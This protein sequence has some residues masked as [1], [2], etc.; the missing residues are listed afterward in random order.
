M[1]HAMLLL[2]L[3]L[4]SS[5]T[6]VAQSDDTFLVLGRT[7]GHASAELTVDAA[8]LARTIGTLYTDGGIISDVTVGFNG[9]RY[10]LSATGQER[11]STITIAMPLATME[12]P[13]HGEVIGFTYSMSPD[14]VVSCNGSCANPLGC[15]IV[16]DSS[17]NPFD[18]Q[19]C[20]GVCT[21]SITTLKPLLRDLIEFGIELLKVIGTFGG[22]VK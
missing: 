9:A 5:F 2:T 21:K 12:D 19:H 14:M 18:C 13:D 16:F 10:Y 17:G 7:S 4:M 6:A 3:A 8:M 1:K 20:D 15:S 11:G 22:P